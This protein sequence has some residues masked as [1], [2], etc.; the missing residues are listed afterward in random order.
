MKHWEEKLKTEM[1]RDNFLYRSED[2]I[3]NMSTS[4]D[5]SVDLTQF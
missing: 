3:G 1:E 4:P 2:N 5:K